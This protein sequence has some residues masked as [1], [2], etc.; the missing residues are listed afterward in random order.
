MDANTSPFSTVAD[1]KNSALTPDEVIRSAFAD[2]IDAERW[3]GWADEA[4]GKVPKNPATGRRAKVNKP[5]TWGTY[6]AARRRA[7]LL[8]N[9]KIGIVPAHGMDLDACRDPKTGELTDWATEIIAAAA[10]YTEISPSGTGVKVFFADG[11]EAAAEIIPMPG[12]ATDDDHTPRIEIYHGRR[13]FAVTGLLVAGTPLERRPAAD[14]LAAVAL[15]LARFRRAAVERASVRTAELKA[16]GIDEPDGPLVWEANILDGIELHE[17]LLR[18]AMSKTRPGS[19]ENEIIADLEALMHESVAKG[20]RRWQTRFKDIKRLVYGGSDRAESEEARMNETMAAF[21]RITG[22]PNHGKGYHSNGGGSTASTNGGTAPEAETTASVKASDEKEHLDLFL[23]T[24]FVKRYGDRVRYVEEWGKYLIYDGKVWKLKGVV[25]GFERIR[26]HV[27]GITRKSCSAKVC[28]AV[29]RLVRGMV[30]SDKNDFDRDLWL[31]NT[32]GGTIDLR[33][34]KLRPHDPKD[35]ITKIT[36]STPQGDC[37]LWKAFLRQITKDDEALVS[38][39]QRLFGYA[40]TGLTVEQMFA[41]FFGKGQNGKSTLLEVLRIVMGDYAGKARSETFMRHR[42]DQHPASVAALMGKRLVIASE[43]PTGAEWNESLIKE[44]TGGEAIE[45]RFMRQDPFE[46]TPQ[47]TLIFLGN[48]KPKFQ[49]I[50]KA[51]KR[52]VQLV[53]FTL[54]IPDEEKDK[55]LPQKLLAEADGILAWA[56]EGCLTWQR[57]GLNPPPVVLDATKDYFADQD[58][59]PEF[60]AECE[61]VADV[62]GFAPTRWLF[63]VWKVYANA[64]NLRI[65]TDQDLKDTLETYAELELTPAEVRIEAPSKRDRTV[66]EKRMHRGVKGL[67][68]IDGWQSVDRI[69]NFWEAF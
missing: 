63:A 11:I 58:K 48:R 53:P 10:T 60:F 41:F 46:F 38:Y 5:V 51:I 49:G 59:L 34:G 6:E 31:L 37:A 61:L 52:R 8:G 30:L 17:S 15:I 40:L 67:K 27:V 4:T 33:T 23:A 36:S 9:N 26:R 7:Q 45:A 55:D 1:Q 16:R 50:D 14:V 64:H 42:H 21:D 29:E 2:V 44:I 56:V 18:L 65:G 39:L 13:F 35:R 28:A 25:T 57:E 68:F 20:S 32:P 19:D 47:M 22:D 69:A 43:I 24:G 62:N 54:V 3:V 66:I 12:E